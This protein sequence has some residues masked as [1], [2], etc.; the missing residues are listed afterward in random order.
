VPI[1]RPFLYCNGNHDSGG[2]FRL[3][4]A[5]SHGGEAL[6]RD[7][8]LDPQ[9]YET[10]I[11]ISETLTWFRKARSVRP[12]GANSPGDSCRESPHHRRQVSFCK[13]HFHDR[14]SAHPT[15]GLLS[16]LAGANAGGL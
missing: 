16:R 13:F 2:K 6:Y 15:D 4:S 3:L 12:R 11:L 8:G 7:Y 5:Q 1:R 9:D 10:N 14:A